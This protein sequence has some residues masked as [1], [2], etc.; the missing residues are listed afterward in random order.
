M[1]L[2]YDCAMLRCL[3]QVVAIKRIKLN[4]D[5][6]EGVPLGSWTVPFLSL[7][8][9]ES[10]RPS[11][12]AQE[13]SFARGGCAKGLGLWVVPRSAATVCQAGFG[14]FGI[15]MLD[16]MCNDVQCQNCRTWIANTL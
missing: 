6:D 7:R 13:H 8:C 15:N 4:P 2:G 3:L 5:D 12:A 10:H 9:T 11:A 14:A 16:T 1:C